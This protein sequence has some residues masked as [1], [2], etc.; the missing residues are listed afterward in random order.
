MP[1][2]RKSTRLRRALYE[3]AQREPSAGGRPGDL[4]VNVCKQ[5][6]LTNMRSATKGI[7][8][9]LSPPLELTLDSAVEY[10][11]EE[12]LVEVTPESIRMAKQRGWNDKNKKGKK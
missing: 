7:V 11:S 8:E 12:E 5:K 2:G 1:S 10:I 3:R 4:R 9:G 6:Q